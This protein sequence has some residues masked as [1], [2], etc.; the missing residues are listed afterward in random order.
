VATRESGWASVIS[1][2]NG[3]VESTSILLGVKQ[4]LRIAAYRASPVSIHGGKEYEQSLA[5]RIA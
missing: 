3:A 2:R 4:T 1:S 5:G